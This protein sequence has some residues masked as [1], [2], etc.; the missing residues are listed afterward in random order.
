MTRKVE[1]M[2]KTN[3]HVKMV[4]E[5]GNTFAILGRCQHAMKRA[6]VWEEYWAEF[7][8]EAISGDYDHLL[9]T[10]MEWFIVDEDEE[11]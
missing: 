9:G 10:V 5:D 11:G 1:K 8:K 2:T 6:R 3:V 4:G 7:H